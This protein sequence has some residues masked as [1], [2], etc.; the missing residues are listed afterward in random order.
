MLHFRERKVGKERRDP[1]NE[2]VKTPFT[3]KKSLVI[4]WSERVDTFDEMM[5]AVKA[6]HN[7]PNL[8]DPVKIGESTV[9]NMH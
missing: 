8:F 2:T 6:S 4:A 1:V 9:Y 7:N 5:A 3:K